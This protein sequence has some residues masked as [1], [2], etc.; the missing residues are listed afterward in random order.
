MIKPHRK[1]IMINKTNIHFT[2]L[3][4]KN[5]PQT[6][7]AYEKTFVMLK[8]DSF[9][10]NIDGIIMKKIDSAGMKVL[11]Q[12]EGIAPRE[13]L[14]RNYIQYKDKPFFSKWIDCL[15]S[16][17]I[18]AMVIGGDD[19][20]SAVSGIKKSV[21]EQYAPGQKRFNLMHSSDDVESAQKECK[22]FFDVEI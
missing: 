10:R 13:K 8:P 21:R 12:W 1:L 17:K 4:T 6:F 5:Y 16:G 7:T 2:P 14:E 22:N 3:Y 15:S 18:R 20:I 9:H 11:S 19:A